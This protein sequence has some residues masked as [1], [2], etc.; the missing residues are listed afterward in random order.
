MSSQAVSAHTKPPDP[1]PVFTVPDMSLFAI[2][3]IRRTGLEQFHDQNH[4][5]FTMLVS[6]VYVGFLEHTAELRK[7]KPTRKSL[8]KL[9]FANIKMVLTA[10]SPQRES[11][12]MEKPGKANVKAVNGIAREFLWGHLKREGVLTWQDFYSEGKKK[13]IKRKA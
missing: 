6:V 9:F 7:Q 5:E 12:Q 8:F 13:K 11:L 4:K 3:A 10:S 2:E 1:V